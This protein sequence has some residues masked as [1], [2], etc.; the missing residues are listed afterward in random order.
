[1]PFRKW[2]KDRVDAILIVWRSAKSHYYYR[3]RRIPKG[4]S[5]MS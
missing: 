3:V 4:A 1:V 5:L 2:R